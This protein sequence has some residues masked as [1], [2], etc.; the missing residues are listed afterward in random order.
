[1]KAL[2]NLES[3]LTTWMHRRVALFVVAI[4]PTHKEERLALPQGKHVVIVENWA[5]SHKSAK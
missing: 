2:T 4:F 3:K 5:I 1:L